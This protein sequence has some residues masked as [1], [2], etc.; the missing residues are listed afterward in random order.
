MAIRIGRLADSSLVARRLADMRLAVCA[1][2]GYLAAHGTPRSLDD[3]AGHDCLGYTLLSDTGT[4]WWAFGR[5]GAVRVPVRGSLHAN[6]GE[7]LVKA[8]C[9][10]QGL[11]YGPRFIA[12]GALAT[13]QLVEVRLDVELMALGAIHAV[14]HATRRPAAKTRAWIDFLA[15]RLPGRAADW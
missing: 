1:S 10:G 7:A 6:N 14:T 15:R 4:S 9:A 2:P 3:L 12:A 13:G 11:V 8:A 5:D